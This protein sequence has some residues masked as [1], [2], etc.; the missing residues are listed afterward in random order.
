MPET[1]RRVWAAQKLSLWVW[2][3]DQSIEGAIG[4]P[5]L[6]VRL[7]RTLEGFDAVALSGCASL[8]LRSPGALPQPPGC[9]LPGAKRFAGRPTVGRS[10]RR[11][12]CPSS[13]R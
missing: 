11:S 7:R 4:A 6:W 3:L 10:G 2:D 9:R 5:V 12:D 13:V 1:V 8:P